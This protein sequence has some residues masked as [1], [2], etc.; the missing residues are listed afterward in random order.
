VAIIL[1]NIGLLVEAVL[2]PLIIHQV[3]QDL[4]VLIMDLQEYLVDHGL[5]QVVEHLE[6]MQEDL[7]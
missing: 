2:V 3:Q 1:A 6:I 7:L 4:V 5:V